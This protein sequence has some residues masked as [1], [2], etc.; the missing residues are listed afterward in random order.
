MGGKEMMVTEEVPTPGAPTPRSDQVTV[1]RSRS[2]LSSIAAVV[3]AIPI[4]W[5]AVFLAAGSLVVGA[6]GSPIGLV[7]F[8]IASVGSVA[9]LAAVMRAATGRARWGAAATVICL[10][11]ACFVVA[12][13]HFGRIPMIWIPVPGFDLVYLI[14]GVATALVLRLLLGPLPLRI[15]GGLAA[16]AI[17][18]ASVLML[19]PERPSADPNAVASRDE[20]FAAFN[21]LHD[22]AL[23]TGAP[24]SVAARFSSPGGLGAISWNLTATD[25]VVQ[26]AR[27]V[28]DPTS[29]IAELL[30]CWILAHRTM[31]LKSTDS[32]S[33]YSRAL[34]EIHPSRDV[35]VDSLS[36]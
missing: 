4:L 3:I 25:A 33:D 7:V 5:T 10:A 8:A 24:G 17:I 36:E 26:I 27:V 6:F 2:S 19:V 13:L 11:L 16:I 9:A 15:V 18:A 34:E 21:R 1:D 23:V 28:S 31:D 12:L 30:P 35:M 32:A 22:T 14:V 20:Q 29:D